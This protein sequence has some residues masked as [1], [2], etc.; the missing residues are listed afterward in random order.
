M[1]YTRILEFYL[2]LYPQNNIEPRLFYRLRTVHWHCGPYLCIQ[3]VYPTLHPYS[4]Y[5]PTLSLLFRDGQ[6][7]G[8]GPRLWIIQIKLNYGLI[9]TIF[10]WYRC[11]YQCRPTIDSRTAYT[12]TV[13]SA[14]SGRVRALPL[15][16]QGQA[17]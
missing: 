7:H 12:R 17:A 9:Q 14:T 4:V 5:H 10:S 1:I 8:F 3:Q 16:L 13:V 6:S 11:R 2:S 15:T